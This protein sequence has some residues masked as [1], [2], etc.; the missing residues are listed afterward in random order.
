MRAPGLIA[1]VCLLAA[2]GGGENVSTS[3][4][5][6]D[7]QTGKTNKP[8]ADKPDP[9]KPAETRFQDPNKLPEVATDV[10]DTLE[11]TELQPDV[12]YGGGTRVKNSVTGT[13][14]AMPESWNGVQGIGGSLFTMAPPAAKQMNMTGQGISGGFMLGLS[15]V[16]DE[17][18]TAMFRAPI[19]LPYLQYTFIFAPQGEP[20]RDGAVIRQN[21]KCKTDYATFVAYAAGAKGPGNNAITFTVGGS[22]S[23]K[24]EMEK[25]LDGLV[26]S[27]K[28]AKPQDQQRR[29]DMLGQISGRKL[30]KINSKYTRNADGT[31][32]SRSEE[33]AWNLHNDGSYLY[34]GDTSFNVNPGAASGSQTSQ[35]GQWWLIVGHS[36]DFLVMLAADGAVNSNTLLNAG[37]YLLMNNEKIGLTAID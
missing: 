11:G 6:S 12:A 1:L 14:F 9:D 10:P 23:E 13:S 16:T 31:S 19:P 33:F 28:F 34:T 30:L 25:V 36:V 21:Y 24:A 17:G 8:V 2:C 29:D 26:K 3:S 5:S 27:V 32:N 15:G 37:G 22:E 4:S 18:L 20:T 7:T 35:R